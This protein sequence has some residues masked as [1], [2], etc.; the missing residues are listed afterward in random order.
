MAAAVQ[1]DVH[2]L[3]QADESL[4]DDKELGMDQPITWPRGNQ[5]AQVGGFDNKQKRRIERRMEDLLEDLTHFMAVFW[6]NGETWGL[7]GV[8]L[9][10][11][12]HGHRV[13]GF[14]YQISG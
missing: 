12:K 13:G 10:E 9:A 6:I 7:G 4:Q 11:K 5:P 8:F 3:R 1:Q 2:C 14:I